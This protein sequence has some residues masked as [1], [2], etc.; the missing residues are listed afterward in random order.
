MNQTD[1]SIKKVGSPVRFFLWG[2]LKQRVYCLIH[3]PF[4]ALKHN[5]TNSIKSLKK[6][7]KRHLRFYKRLEILKR[8][9]KYLT[10]L[11]YTFKKFYVLPKTKVLTR[12]E[13]FF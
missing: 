10:V 2:H 1:F 9:I 6:L 11:S 13:I 12:W 4:D 7:L 8:I 3:H 5:I